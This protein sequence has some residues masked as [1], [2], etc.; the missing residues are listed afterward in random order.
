LRTGEAI[1]TG[2]AALLP[3]RCRIALPPENRRPSSEDPSV[4][5]A[6]SNERANSNYAR[7]IAAWRAQNAQFTIE[8][9]D[10]GTSTS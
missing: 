7:P 4:S 5:K 2:E 10:D 6:W 8:G 1:I 9:N 3:I